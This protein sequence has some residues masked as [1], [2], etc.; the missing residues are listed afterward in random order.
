M[1]S[2]S[3][4]VRFGFK[5]RKSR[6]YGGMS[7]SPLW[8]HPVDATLYLEGERWC[9]A[10]DQGFRRG[11]RQPRGR[12]Y[13]IAGS[14]ESR[15]KRSGERWQAGRRSRT[16]QSVVDSRIVMCSDPDFP[17]GEGDDGY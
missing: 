1:R 11:L 13:G 2:P 16:L 9:V 8:F 3:Q 17:F 10:M 14:A 4:V 6:P 15:S 5:K 7:A 12:S